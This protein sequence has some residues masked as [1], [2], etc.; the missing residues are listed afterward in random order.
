MELRRQ[1]L[2]LG[3]TFGR[4]RIHLGDESVERLHERV[5]DQ[6]N[7]GAQELFNCGLIRGV[8]K[9]LDQ[10]HLGG[11]GR[12]GLQ[13]LKHFLQLAHAGVV[14][15]LGSL[16]K[17][18]LHQVDRVLGEA[19]QIVT[20]RLGDVVLGQDLVDEALGLPI[21]GFELLVMSST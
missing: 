7:I 17:H 21:A 3:A 18:G 20:G 11:R 9:L 12:G 2:G 1:R 16:T 15:L 10:S 8:K 19:V 4:L 14:V 6:A 13:D 5:I